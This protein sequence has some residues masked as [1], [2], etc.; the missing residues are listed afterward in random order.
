[1]TGSWTLPFLGSIAL[2][3]IGAG[4]ALRL[5]PDR[6]LVDPAILSADAPA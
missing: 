1:V 6:P 3:L 5:R 2:L 4:L